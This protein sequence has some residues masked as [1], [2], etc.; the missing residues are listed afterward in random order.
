MKMRDIQTKMPRRPDIFRNI[1]DK[2]KTSA[3]I[4]PAESFV[5][6]QKCRFV[7][8]SGKHFKRTPQ[9]LV[10]PA[11]VGFYFGKQSPPLVR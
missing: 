5:E 7:F 3:L 1:F 4:G 2:L 9:F 11:Q 6:K 8:R 10:K